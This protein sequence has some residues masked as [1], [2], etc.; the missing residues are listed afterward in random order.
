MRFNHASFSV[1]VFVLYVED[2]PVNQQVL[3]SMLDQHD[4]VELAV[5]C[6]EEEVDEILANRPSLPDLVLMD[7][8]L[9]DTTGEK[10]RTIVR[11]AP[12]ARS[13][14]AQCPVCA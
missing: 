10:A 8:Q 4:N 9:S 6:D 13:K 11:L 2:D 1:P 5:A 3:E 7:S 12:A 14:H